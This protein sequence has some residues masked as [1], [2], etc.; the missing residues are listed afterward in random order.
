MNYGVGDKVITK[1]AHP[2][3]C[4]TFTITR[5]GADVKIVCEKCG[6]SIMMDSF[7]FEKSIKKLIKEVQ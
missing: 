6:R 7:K 1:K 3:G 5:V 4:D 2:C